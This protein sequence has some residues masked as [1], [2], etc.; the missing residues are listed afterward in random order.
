MAVTRQSILNTAKSISGTYLMGGA[1]PSQW[2]CS[3]FVGHCV[4]APIGTRYFATPNEGAVLAGM[5]FKDVR[6]SVDFRSG[7]GMKP[8]DI[9]VWNKPGTSGLYADGHTE[10]YY[11]NGLTIGA[12]GPSGS[13]V[14]MAAGLANVGR[15]GWQQCWR[16]KGGV[17]LIKWEP[18]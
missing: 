3:G 4:G 18:L 7:A 9:L 11:G 8:G 14:G 15:I 13:A 5:G 2:D 12:R 17:A 10:I 1:G 6:G 16:A